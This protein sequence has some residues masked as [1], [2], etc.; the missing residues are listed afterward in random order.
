MIAA[1]S[2]AESNWDETLGTLRYADRAK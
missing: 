2:P 1:V